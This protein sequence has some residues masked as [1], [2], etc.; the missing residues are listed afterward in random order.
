MDAAAAAACAAGIVVFAAAGDNDSSDGGPTP[1]NVDLPASAPH[2]I[3]CGGTSKSRMA[4]EIVWNNNPGKTNG[5]GTGGG[6]STLFGVQSVAG[7]RADAPSGR[8]VPDIAAN[9]DPDTGYEIPLR[10]RSRRRHERGR[11][12]VLGPVRRV[13]HQARICDAGAVS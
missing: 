2:V 13:R 7:R 10:L 3:G 6:F 9:A 12:A 4:S 11:A 8:M 1:A 5:E